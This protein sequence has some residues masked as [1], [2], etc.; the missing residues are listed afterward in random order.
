MK[1]EEKYV[2]KNDTVGI[3][4]LKKELKVHVKKKAKA[5]EWYKKKEEIP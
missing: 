4:I 1:G 5:I 3:N 2:A